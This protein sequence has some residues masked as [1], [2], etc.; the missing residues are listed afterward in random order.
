M[1]AGGL[2]ARRQYDLKLLLA[3]GTVSQL[4]FLFV[5]FGTGHRSAPRSP[6]PCSSLRTPSSRPRCSWWSGSSNTRPAPATSDGSIASSELEPDAGRSKRSRPARHPWRASRSTLGFLAKES[7]YDAFAHGQIGSAAL[8]VTRALVLGSTITVAYAVRFVVGGFFSPARDIACSTNSVT[9]RARRAL[10][11]SW[12]A[13]RARRRR[14][15]CSASLPRSSTRFVDAAVRSLVAGVR[16][17]CRRGSGIGG[18]PRAR[19]LD[20]DLTRSARCS[21]CARPLG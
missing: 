6:A 12:P 1:I 13:G 3:Y 10:A 21:A 20:R 14:P 18:V 7:A 15:R 2:R 19:P 5:L 16:P 11:C 8:V 17:A 4:G 9:A